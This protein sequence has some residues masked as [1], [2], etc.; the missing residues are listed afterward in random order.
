MPSLTNISEDAITVIAGGTRETVKPGADIQMSKVD[1]AMNGF[2]MLNFIQKGAEVI[3]SI[4]ETIEEV[5]ETIADAAESVGATTIEKVAETVAAV[6]EVVEV[7][8]EKAEGKK[9]A[10]KDAK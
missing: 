7:V 9:P 1:I 4:A 6:A 10:A 3:E 2:S 5:A 8:A